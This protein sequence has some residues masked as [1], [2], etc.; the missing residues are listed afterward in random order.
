MAVRLYPIKPKGLDKIDMKRLFSEIKKVCQRESEQHRRMF[1]Q[2]TKTWNHPPR[3]NR[4]SG[5]TA[6][7]IFSR[8]ST[9]SK[10][11]AYVELGTPVRYMHMS[12]DFLPKSVPGSLRARKGAGRAAKLS[13]PKPG[14]VARDFRTVIAK[15]RSPIFAAKV[16]AVIQ[17]HLS[18]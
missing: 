13:W 11:F 12:R 15:K 17:S 6:N 9:N 16:A 1:G 3:F 18:P 2:A 10:P 7:S 5:Q 4:V 14:L 8:L